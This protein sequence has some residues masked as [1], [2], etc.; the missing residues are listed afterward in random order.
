M[1]ICA[2]F[3]KDLSKVKGIPALNLNDTQQLPND[4]IL[5]KMIDGFEN[6]EIILNDGN[7]QDYLESQGSMTYNDMYTA[8]VEVLDKIKEKYRLSKLRAEHI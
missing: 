6:Y 3:R 4:T 1:E 7:D 2:L 5:D 8:A